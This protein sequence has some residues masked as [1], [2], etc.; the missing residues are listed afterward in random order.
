MHHCRTKRAQQLRFREQHHWLVLILRVGFAELH[1]FM[2]LQ[3][4]HHGEMCRRNAPVTDATPSSI[5][6]L[7]SNK[8]SYSS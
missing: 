1:R 2:L 4:Q 8:Q 3:L 5:S 7:H 6:L